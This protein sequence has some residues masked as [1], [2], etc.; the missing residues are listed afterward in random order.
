MKQPG[1]WKQANLQG[2]AV[3]TGR[4]KKMEP[5]GTEQVTGDE[6]ENKS[7]WNVRPDKKEEKEKW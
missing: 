3:G 6:M 7:R 2:A 4:Q 5:K 1:E